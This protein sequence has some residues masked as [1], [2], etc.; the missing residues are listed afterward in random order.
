MYV[1][2]MLMKPEILMEVRECIIDMPPRKCAL[3]CTDRKPQMSFCQRC[4]KAP[5]AT[6][7]SGVLC[8]AGSLEVSMHPGSWYQ[9]D[10]LFSL[11]SLG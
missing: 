7:G 11:L 9:N 5:A 1:L 3:W 2:F 10:V 4:E 6:S 8:V